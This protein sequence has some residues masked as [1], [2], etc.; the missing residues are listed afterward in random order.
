LCKER[1][2]SN[3]R[4]S[5][6]LE[7]PDVRRLIRTKPAKV[8]YRAS[9][10][11]SAPQGVNATPFIRRQDVYFPDTV[12]FFTVFLRWKVR[13]DLFFDFVLARPGNAP[14]PERSWIIF[15]SRNH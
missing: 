5:E 14:R 13:R 3:G 1:C 9:I 4:A 7:R 10:R 15:H 12:E 6:G 11:L 2:F 8:N